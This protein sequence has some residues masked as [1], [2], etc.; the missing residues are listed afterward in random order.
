MAKI[1]VVDDMDMARATIRQMLERGGHT[2]L[3]AANGKEGLKVI[4]RHPPDVVL[5]DIL[6]PE[7]E[8]LEFIRKLSKTYPHLPIVAFSAST[9]TPYLEAAVRMGAL[10]GLAKPFKQAELF[11]AIE[12]AL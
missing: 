2:V 3:E 9:T 11:A 5:T 7:M 1:L 12:R 6:M 10:G 8:G 4:K